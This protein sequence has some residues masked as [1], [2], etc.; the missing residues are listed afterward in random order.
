M[1]GATKS[2]G[3]VHHGG[4]GKAVRQHVNFTDFP[5]G[6]FLPIWRAPSVIYSLSAKYQIARNQ[7]GWSGWRWTGQQEYRKQPHAQ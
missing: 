6:Q 4:D 5:G 7:M 1:E 2:I 3:P